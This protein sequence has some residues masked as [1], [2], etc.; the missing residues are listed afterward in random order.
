MAGMEPHIGSFCL[1]SA[2]GIT[3][4]NDPKKVDWEKLDALRS[5]GLS[6]WYA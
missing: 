2:G 3:T 5:I 6:P 4:N 1:G